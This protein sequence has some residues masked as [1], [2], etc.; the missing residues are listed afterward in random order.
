M[1][2]AVPC[3]SY[4]SYFRVIFAQLFSHLS[5]ILFDSFEIYFSSLAL[6][7][8]A[9]IVSAKCELII[10][11]IFLC[12]MCVF[13]FYF[14]RFSLLFSLILDKRGEMMSRC[15]S[16]RKRERW[17]KGSAAYGVR[18]LMI[19]LKCSKC[20]QTNDASHAYAPVSHLFYQSNAFCL[21]G[22]SFNLDVI[23]SAAWT[24]TSLGQEHTP[25]LYFS[26]AWRLMKFLSNEIARVCLFIAEIIFSFSYLSLVTSRPDAAAAVAP[27]GRSLGVFVCH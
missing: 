13:F 27:G 1:D 14:S 6:Q 5:V 2:A 11:S 23:M 21:N 16:I 17:A 22:A 19:Y 20:A 4:S 8:S 18:W 24:N 12:R 26:W 3:G 7:R 25:R 9:L 15:F 10:S